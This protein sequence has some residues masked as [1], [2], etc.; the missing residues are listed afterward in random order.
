MPMLVDP[1]GVRK[2]KNLYFLLP[3]A[4]TLVLSLANPAQAAAPPEND[5][6]LWTQASAIVKLNNQWKFSQDVIGRFSDNREGL[7][8]VEM[9]SMLN[10]RIAKN[11][12]VAAGYVRNPQYAAGDFTIMEQRARE[13]VTFDNIA[14]L[15]GGKFSVR[16]RMEQR[17]RDNLDGTGWRL[18]PFV[19]YSVPLSGKTS[20]VLS[21]EPFYN[22]NKTVFQAREGFDRVRNF[23]G[24]N[25][26]LAK[27]LTAEVGYLNQ[28]GFVRDAPDTSDNVGSVT[29]TLS[30]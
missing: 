9:V 8:E 19:K 20:L 11:V 3:T 29:L 10:Y 26:P 5:T 24:I 28:H 4:A 14:E 2:V 12:T 17:W 27:N 18:R 1:N 30:L 22:L 21:S 23:I 6:Q 15:A 13:Q 25:Q 16:M 7:Y